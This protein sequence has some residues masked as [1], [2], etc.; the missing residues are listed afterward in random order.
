MTNRQRFRLLVASY[1]R[2]AAGLSVYGKTL[3]SLLG[4]FGVVQKYLILGLLPVMISY[5][6]LFK[7]LQRY[8]QFVA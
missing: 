6:V 4:L 5:G 1:H 7:P 2:R 3:P 8:N